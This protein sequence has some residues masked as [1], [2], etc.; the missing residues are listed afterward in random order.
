MMKRLRICCLSAQRK[1]LFHSRIIKITFLPFLSLIAFCF[2]VSP[3]RQ[4]GA[5][6]VFVDAKI[7]F[8]L[9]HHVSIF[10]KN[11]RHDI[12]PLVIHLNIQQREI[13][14]YK[15]S[16]KFILKVFQFHT[17]FISKDLS[18]IHKTSFSFIINLIYL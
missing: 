3:L 11:H 5:A 2:N 18:R 10:S 6:I 15:G 17:S 13:Y 1:K 16:N 8:F 14:I 12:L 4:S 7:S 9:V